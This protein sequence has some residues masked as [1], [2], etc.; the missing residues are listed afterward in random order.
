MPNY[1][2]VE[3][4]VVEAKSGIGSEIDFNTMSGEL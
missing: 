4:E 1:G 2:R 3:I